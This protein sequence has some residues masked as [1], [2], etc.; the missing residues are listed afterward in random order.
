MDKY[1]INMSKI[2][3]E[4]PFCKSRNT[5]STNMALCSYPAQF[6]YECKDCHKLFYKL[7]TEITEED[8]NETLDR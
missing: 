3:P 6:E 7:R 8:L 5:K 1:N 2:T 4:C